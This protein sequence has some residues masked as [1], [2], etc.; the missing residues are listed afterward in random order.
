MFRCLSR[1]SFASI[2]AK[3]YVD[4]HLQGLFDKLPERLKKNRPDSA[5]S[6][7]R[8][9]AT[10]AS[11]KVSDL[12]IV[13]GSPSVVK[14]EGPQVGVAKAKTFP[15]R[16][17]TQTPGPL[18]TEFPSVATTSNPD[19]RQNFQAIVSPS[20]MS[21]TSTPDSS[22]AIQNMGHSPYDG[23]QTSG[24]N[25]VLPQVGAMMFPSTDPFAYPSRPAMTFQSLDMTSANTTSEP[26][27][28]L[29]TDDLPIYNDVQGQLFGPL[30]PWIR[31][32]QTMEVQYPGNFDHSMMS[33]ISGQD[34]N[35]HTGFTPNAE[36][37]LDGIFQGDDAGWNTTGPR[38][39]Q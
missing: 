31:G 14:L 36:T 37:N 3:T 29:R 2:L 5:G 28:F 8:R 33:G 16:T 34:V 17:S 27:S 13:R 15:T 11:S 25:S 4:E 10:A 24:A 26:P 21:S 12:A 6:R 32:P 30:P 38:Y 9:S 22:S 20:F 1:R 23:P 18:N 39:N 7:K 19:L 35:Y